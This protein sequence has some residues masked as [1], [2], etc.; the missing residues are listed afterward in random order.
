MEAL[1][2][3]ILWQYQLVLEQ[4]CLQGIDQVLVD[5]MFM[6]FLKVENT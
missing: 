3:C 1:F 5:Q 2:S 6:A 4:S